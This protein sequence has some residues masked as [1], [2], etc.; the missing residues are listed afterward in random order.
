M[1]PASQLSGEARA[2]CGVRQPRPVFYVFATKGSIQQRVAVRRRPLHRQLMRRVVC[3]DLLRAGTKP[4]SS[5]V[6][7]LATMLRS[8]FSC[9]L[10][11]L[12]APLVPSLMDSCVVGTY[13]VPQRV[14]SLFDVGE[15]HVLLF[16]SP[17]RERHVLPAQNSGVR[18]LHTDERQAHRRS[19]KCPHFRQPALLY[20]FSR[21]LVD[22]SAHNEDP[23]CQV[24]PPLAPDRCCTFKA[25]RACFGDA[26]Q[27]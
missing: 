8:S 21:R 1:R 24:W 13:R 25:S 12:S 3:K 6:Q 23:Y 19:P 2:G 11:L 9:V 4:E 27:L 7:C 22:G 16:Y 14:S 15:R 26:A 10:D 17:S 5:D 18:G 20:V